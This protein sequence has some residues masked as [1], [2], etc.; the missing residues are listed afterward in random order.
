M[1]A[2]DREGCGE[3]ADV[4][5]ELALGAL[6]G[7]ERGAAVAH[8][9]RCNRCRDDVRHL[10]AV[11]DELLRLLPASEPPPG[12]EAAVMDGFAGGADVKP[13]S[14]RTKGF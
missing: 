8:L 11:G 2:L 10:V 3:L 4:V 6:T 13:R 9:E 7:R 14:V 12:F 5:A 1:S